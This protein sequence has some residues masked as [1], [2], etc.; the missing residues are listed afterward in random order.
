MAV[1]REPFSF[2][3]ASASDVDFAEDVEAHRRRLCAH[4]E[5][6]IAGAET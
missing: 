2:T 3:R 4:R 6:P 1:V 5:A